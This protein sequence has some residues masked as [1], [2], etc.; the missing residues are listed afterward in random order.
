MG[1]FAHCFLKFG[2]NQI[3][4][5]NE[6]AGYVI[7]CC[8]LCLAKYCC[9]YSTWLYQQYSELDSL[10]FWVF[11]LQSVCYDYNKAQ[12]VK[13]PCVQRHF[14]IWLWLK[15]LR[16]TET[17]WK[18]DNLAVHHIFYYIKNFWRWKLKKSPKI[19]NYQTRTAMR[20]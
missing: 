6:W 2:W 10:I 9:T 3:L 11:L 12:W 16:P 15:V 14:V 13:P 17:W 19:Y 4:H 1:L 7:Y 8:V 5:F 18:W 20:L